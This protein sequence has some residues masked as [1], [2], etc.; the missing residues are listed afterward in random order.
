MTGGVP[1]LRIGQ[2]LDVHRFSDQPE[3]MLILGGVTVKGEGARGLE[4]HSDAD[5]VAHAIADAVLGAAGLGDLGR[6][7]PDTDP[8]WRG[9]DSIGMLSQMVE[10]ARRSGWAPVNADCTVMAEQP[11][12]SPFV[13]Q[14][15]ERLG[16]AL[17]APVNVKATRAEGL[18]A[19]GRGEGIA[20]SAV[21]L[22]TGV[23]PS[24]PEGSDR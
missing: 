13:E 12:L 20:C 19:L 4:G 18:G 8:Q 16:A 21:V 9:A 6:H 11:R 14:M 15:S 23:P 17:G 22:M 7:A 2:G 5:V 24:G 10:L 1:D 3:R